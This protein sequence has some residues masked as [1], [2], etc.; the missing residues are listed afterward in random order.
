MKREIRPHK[1]GRAKRF[2]SARIT[3]EHLKKLNEILERRKMSAADWVIE[4]IEQ[5]YGRINSPE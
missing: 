4:K 5:E 3:P 1:G 2:P